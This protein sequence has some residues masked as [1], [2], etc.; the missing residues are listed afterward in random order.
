MHASLNLHLSVVVEMLTDSS[1]KDVFQLIHAFKGREKFRKMLKVGVPC[2]AVKQAMLLYGNLDK[3]L[4]DSS[5]YLP[6]RPLPK[7]ERY[8]KKLKIG[9]PPEAVSEKMTL[10]GHAHDEE[11]FLQEHLDKFP[12]HPSHQLLFGIDPRFE[13]FSKMLKIGIPTEAV[14]QKMILDGYADDAGTFFQE[15]LA[16]PH[17]HHRRQLPVRLVPQYEV[18]SKMLKIGIPTEAVRQKMILDGYADDADT[19]LQ[20]HLA[21][22]RQHRRRQLPVR[23]DPQY[24]IY[25]KMLEIGIPVEAIRQKMTLD[26]YAD[27]AENI[28]WWHNL[29]VND[30]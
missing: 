30:I 20:E 21:G 16:R 11:T 10:D 18:Y 25:S 24:E 8:P 26:G 27:D 17:Q 7:F 12:R 15:Y 19:F 22:T 28:Y 29:P 9:L 23:L 2:G 13:L 4:P 3:T 14:R 1:D 5:Q 6:S